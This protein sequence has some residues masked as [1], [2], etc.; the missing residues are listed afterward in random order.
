MEVERQMKR[1][2]PRNSPELQG[3][4]PDW[5]HLG[6]EKWSDSGWILQVE[7]VGLPDVL[8]VQDERKTEPCL[9]IKFLS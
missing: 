1:L 4:E 3:L 9:C 7:P 6:S 5:E 2:W 8:A